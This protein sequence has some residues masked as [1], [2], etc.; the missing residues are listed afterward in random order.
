MRNSILL[1]VII[2][3][4]AC[5]NAPKNEVAESAATEI[6]IKGEAQGTT[7]T[8]KYLA[9]EY[10]EG[11][12]EHFDQLLDDIDMS[13]STYVPNSKISRLNAGDTIELDDLFLEVYNLSYSINKKTD[14]AFDPTIGP[15]IKAWGFDF[16][17]PQKMDSA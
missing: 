6:V 5:T 9:E 13:M 8:I 14:G 7:Y 11:L 12:K 3:F 17:N 4:F 15:L 2:S 16:A 10:E 1:I